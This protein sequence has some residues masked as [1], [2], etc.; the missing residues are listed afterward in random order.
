VAVQPLRVLC[1]TKRHAQSATLRPQHSAPVRRTRLSQA[2]SAWQCCRLLLGAG[3]RYEGVITAVA[4]TA[5]AVYHCCDER[6]VRPSPTTCS[7]NTHWHP[8]QR[9][10]FQSMGY[11]SFATRCDSHDCTTAGCV[12]RGWCALSTVAVVPHNARS[13][14]APAERLRLLLT[15]PLSR[16]RYTSSPHNLVEPYSSSRSRSRRRNHARH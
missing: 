9:G 15:G 16:F 3:L 5:S 12:L 14:L 11:R 6:L 1:T 4:G 13:Q 2:L 8:A 7:A 10:W